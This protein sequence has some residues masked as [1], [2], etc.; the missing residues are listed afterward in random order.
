VRV[1]TA[2]SFGATTSATL[3]VGGVSAD[4]AVTTLVPSAGPFWELFF[5]SEPGSWVGGGR[6]QFF[7]FGPGHPEMLFSVYRNGANTIAVRVMAADISTI[8][9][10][11]LDGPG[12]A[13]LI[14]GRYDNA[15]LYPGN[16]TGTGLS[17]TGDG[18]G[19][20]SISGSFDILEL[21]YGPSGDVQ[22]LAVNFEQRCDL[23]PAAVFGQLRINSMVPLGSNPIRR[24]RGDF[25]ADGFSDILWR[26]ATTGQNYL[27]PMAGIN[28]LSPEGYFRTVADPNWKIVGTGDFDG[29][30][31]TDILW[32]NT[33]TGQNYIYFMDGISIV[34]EGY[35]RTISDPNWQVAGIGD[36]DG[37][38][39]DDILWRNRVTGENYLYPMV[40]TSIKP[41][42]GNLRAVA[43]P[44]WQVA[45]V[46]DF[47]GDGKADILWRNN[48]TG[49]NYIYPMDGTAIKSSEG[50]VRTVAD[51]AWQVKGVG[52][53]D[54][55][56]KADILWR[57]TATG[58]NYLYPMDGTT[59]KPTEAYIRTVVNLAW[60][61]A[62]VADYDGDGRPDILWRNSSTGE[63][64]IY[65]MDGSTIKPNEG[66]VRTVPD[67]AW[68]V[69]R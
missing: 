46:G 63:N 16:G 30:G 43:D 11:A 58:E 67:Q 32:R 35:I 53:F 39:K 68:R 24:R 3:T 36:F 7:Q 4:F 48:T 55:D 5:V 51:M 18:A 38:G 23:N 56:G 49:A 61:I 13:V 27:Y 14:P 28:I 9:D 17:F 37:D 15:S 62:A 12:S 60:D 40:G 1:A 47:D 25:N 69:V 19:C 54:G 66:F 41:S 57:N 42:E 10:L 45:G 8:W 2:A 31:R 65:P 21:S 44:A 26:N 29:D 6:T 52:D 59:I 64:Y 22:R 20:S 34:G 50:Y 33:S